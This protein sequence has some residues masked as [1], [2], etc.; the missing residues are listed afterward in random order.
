MCSRQSFCAGILIGIVA[1]AGALTSPGQ[2]GSPRR[3]K[4][5]PAR[6]M[7]V[8]REHPVEIAFVGSSDFPDHTRSIRNAIQMAVDLQPVVRGHVVQI[9]VSDAPCFSG[10]NVEAANMATARAIVGEPQNTAVIGHLCSSGFR[11]ALPVY[12]YAGLTTISGSASATDLPSLGLTVFNRTV[13]EDPNAEAWYGRVRTLPSV[14]AFRE[15]YEAEFDSPPT[16]FADLY[17]DAASLVLRRLRQ[18][19]RLDEHGNLVID[20]VRLAR[21]V[22]KT[23][24]Y[25][26]VTCRVTLDGSGNRLDDPTALDRCSKP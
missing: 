18:T 7:V 21:A 17:F 12:E 2:A 20:R 5:A 9:N 10:A 15:D 16:D 19:S 1:L 14:L 22:R 13:V 11:S 23:R 3:A 24:H 4:V 6:V 8:P 25:Y 26:G